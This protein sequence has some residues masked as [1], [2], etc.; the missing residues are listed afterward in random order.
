[1]GEAPGAEEDRQGLPFVGRAG[2]LLNEL[3]AGI[4]MERER[5]LDL[6]RPQ[7]PPTGK[8]R[9]PADRDRVLRALPA[10][11]VELIEPRVIATLGGFATKL[12]TGS[13]GRDHP[14]SRDTQ[15]VH[16]IGGPH[17]VR[18]APS[19]PGRRVAHAGAGRH[20]ARGLREA[21]RAGRAGPARAGGG[22]R[23]PRPSS[24]P[25]RRAGEPPPMSS[26][27]SVD[28]SGRR[29]AKRVRGPHGGDRRRARGRAR[30]GRRGPR[31]RRAGSRQDHA[32]KG[33]MSRARR[34]PSRSFRRPSRSA[35]ATGGGSGSHTSTCF[36]STAWTWRI[37]AS[38]RLCVRGCDH[39]R[40]RG[41]LGLRRP[42]PRTG[43]AR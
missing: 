37:R 14:G 8:P 33:G 2:G 13:R 34:L 10:R 43:P 1:M 38:R 30:A 7:V 16:E 31:Q 39:L 6:Q 27:C 17:R 11:Q 5:R 18:H 36:A 20:P 22:T 35:G 42:G 40:G 32:H 24:R 29:A 9:T 26:T 4:G 19:P 28:E 3:L 23:P 12:L 41:R 25:S 15:Q 21:R